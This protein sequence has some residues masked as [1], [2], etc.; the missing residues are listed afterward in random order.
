MAM[1]GENSIFHEKQ[2]FEDEE[3]QASFLQ[4]FKRKGLNNVLNYA[5]NKFQTIRVMYEALSTLGRQSGENCIMKRTKDENKSD[6]ARKHGNKFFCSKNLEKA[7]HSYQEALCYAESDFQKA[8]CYGNISAVFFQLKNPRA[9]LKNIEMARKFYPASGEQK[10]LNKMSAREEAC[11]NL[12]TVPVPQD[13]ILSHPA[14]ANIP[15]L[16]VNVG[17]RDPRTRNQHLYARNNLKYGD[18]IAVT[19]S[20]QVALDKHLAMEVNPETAYAKNIHF[21]YNCGVCSFDVIYPCDNC[22]IIQF[23]SETCKTEYSESVHDFECECFKYWTD[24]YEVENLLALL[25]TYR[26]LNAV[27]DVSQEFTSCF[28]WTDGGQTLND[29]AKCL[30]GSKQSLITFE[31]AFRLTK[32]T[33]G[34]RDVLRTKTEYKELISR[35]GGDE[36]IFW[37][38]YGKIY[39]KVKIGSFYNDFRKIV[40]TEKTKDL[41]E[42]AS[43]VDTLHGIFNH[44]CRPNVFVFRPK[45]VNKNF[46][47]IGEDVKAGQEL[48]I[49]YLKVDDSTGKKVRI[50]ILNI[51]FGFKC[52]CIGCT[53][54]IFL[55]ICPDC[56]KDA[57]VWLECKKKSLGINQANTIFRKFI[58]EVHRGFC[59]NDFVKKIILSKGLKSLYKIQ[60]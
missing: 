37:D 55:M 29:R 3:D 10:F 31:I 24:Q 45:H 41:T 17:L 6:Y 11:K 22:A 44:S 26:F 38:L 58:V 4:M 36:T 20:F 52:K 27:I 48:T 51:R 8:F 25:W 30:L 54:L 42:Y 12:T 59:K 33:L 40:Q 21:C 39:R 28:D 50:E 7:F 32:R 5:E 46:Y 13:L 43:Y 19:E 56:V 2:A 49:S 14:H 15:G 53:Q 1:F 9:S 35:Y 60:Y 16:S 18:V 23:C 57:L 47:I 34:L